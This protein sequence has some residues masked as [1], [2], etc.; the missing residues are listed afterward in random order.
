MMT[1]SFIPKFTFLFFFIS[2]LL[3]QPPPFDPFT[4]AKSVGDENNDNHDESVRGMSYD[5]A[6]DI[7]AFFN[8]FK[9]M[10]FTWDF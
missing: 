4:R 2:E 8:L 10:S 9:Q 6:P 5:W 3:T 1:L 7:I